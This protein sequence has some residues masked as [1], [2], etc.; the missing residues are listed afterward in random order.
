MSQE[1]VDAINAVLEKDERERCLS[2]LI[3]ETAEIECEIIDRELQAAPP[4]NSEWEQWKMGDFYKSKRDRRIEILNNWNA[5]R[6]QDGLW[7]S[8]QR[9]LE[10]LHHLLECAGR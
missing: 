4:S 7:A 9:Q 10:Q 3:K 8:R 2:P 1:L 6:H 5:R